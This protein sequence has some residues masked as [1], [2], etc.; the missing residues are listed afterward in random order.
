M[1]MMYAPWCGWSKKARPEFEK[2]KDEVHGQNVN[3]VQVHASVVDS[4]ENKDEVKKHADKIQG[5]PTFLVEIY[6]GGKHVATEIVDVSERTYD[7]FVDA[8]KKITNNL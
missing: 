6:D 7:G 1:K 8:I 4:E 5:F 2:F 3:G